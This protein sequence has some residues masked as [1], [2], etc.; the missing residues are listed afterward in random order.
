MGAFF[1]GIMAGLIFGLAL[2][3]EVKPYLER[4]AVA[5]EKINEES[6]SGE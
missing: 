4:I 5:L 2:S 6:V 3:V 1:G